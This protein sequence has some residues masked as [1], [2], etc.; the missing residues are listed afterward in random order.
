M[1]TMDFVLDPPTGVGPLR[2]GSSREEATAAL[3]ELRFPGHVHRSD[4]PGR[5]LFRP[6]GLSFNLGC[7]RGVL[8][9]VE[10][11][12]PSGG[13]RVL[14]RGIDLFGLPAKEVAARLGEV[15]RL[16]EDEDGEAGFVAPDLLLALWRSFESDDD[17]D[18]HQGYYFSSVLLAAPGYYDTPAEAALRAQGG[19]V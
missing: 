6:S 12:R 14:Y 1:P 17:P 13:D 7:V 16:V 4:E 2:I 10:M 11:G 15:T 18:D 9:S 19:Q 8:E 3:E 5:W